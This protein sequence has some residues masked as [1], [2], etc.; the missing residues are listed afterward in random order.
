MFDGLTEMRCSSYIIN[1][2]YRNYKT[3][4]FVQDSKVWHVINKKHQ[5]PSEGAPS[6]E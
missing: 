4:V 6:E 3:D 5:G 1:M 2:S